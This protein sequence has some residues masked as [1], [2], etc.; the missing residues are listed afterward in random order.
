MKKMKPFIVQKIQ[1]SNLILLIVKKGL[2]FEEEYFKET[3]TPE[4][5]D[6]NQTLACKLREDDLSRR[7]YAKC[8]N[9]HINVSILNT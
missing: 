1:Y 5:I 4:E 3:P 6:Y 9:K 2:K 7:R 8:I